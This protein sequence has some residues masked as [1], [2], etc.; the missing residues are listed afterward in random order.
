MEL[1]QIEKELF[2]FTVGKDEI[3]FHAVDGVLKRV[4][5]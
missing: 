2:V 4:Y 3:L 1:K 5:S